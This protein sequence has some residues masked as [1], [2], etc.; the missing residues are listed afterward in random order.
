MPATGHDTRPG[1]GRPRNARVSWWWAAALGLLASCEGEPRFEHHAFDPSFDELQ[2]ELGAGDV[3]ICGDEVEQIEVYA[4]LHGERVELDAKLDGRHLRLSQACHGSWSCSVDLVVVVP[5]RMEV[6]VD[7]GSGDLFAHGLE[8]S[9]HADTG[10]GDVVLAALRAGEVAVS[11]GSGDVRG[12]GLAV[13]RVDA[14]TGSGDVHLGLAPV[15]APRR[16]RADTGSGDVVLDLPAGAYA[17]DWST[18]SGDLDIQDIS[19][20]GRATDRIEVDTGSG[21][22]LLRGR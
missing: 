16:V 2:V 17:L 14:D 1:R 3:E 15:D 10:S 21:D 8:G 12:E 20:D 18:G 6:W 7:T 22:I 13:L 19:I 9:V 5:R 4:E 11:T